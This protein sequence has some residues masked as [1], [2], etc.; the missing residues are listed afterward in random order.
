MT[1]FLEDLIL[2]FLGEHYGRCTYNI[3]ILFY[4]VYWEEDHEVET[5]GGRY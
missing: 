3:F 1:R 5:A 2:I 4:G